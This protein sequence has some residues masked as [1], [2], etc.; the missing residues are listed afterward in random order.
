[1]NPQDANPA[2]EVMCMCSG[3]TRGSIQRMFEQGL[4]METISRKSGALSG[5]GGCEWDIGEFLK[6]L[7]AQQTSR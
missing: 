4:D 2:D 3:T 7:S 6:E 1:M 5:C